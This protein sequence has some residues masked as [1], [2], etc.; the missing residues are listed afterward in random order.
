MKPKELPDDFYDWLTTKTF[1]IGAVTSL[2]SDSRRP[3]R[4]AGDNR[5]KPDRQSFANSAGIRQR[6]KLVP[7]WIS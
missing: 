1:E 4:R 2:A 7:H 6:V 3:V 5:S